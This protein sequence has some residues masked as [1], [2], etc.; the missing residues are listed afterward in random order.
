MAGRSK[1]PRP[2]SLFLDANVLYSAGC[3]DLMIEASLE[4]LCR[5]LWSMQVLTEF[6]AALLRTRPDLKPAQIHRL[7]GLLASVCPDALQR[8]RPVDRIAL[9]PLDDPADAHVLLGAY[10]ARAEIIITFN[11]RHFPRRILGPIGLVA[12]SPDQWLCSMAKPAPGV[13]NEIAERCRSRLVRPPL[14]RADHFE[15]LRRS[16]LPRFAAFLASR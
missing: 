10:E 7:L 1:S 9:P 3:R 2:V 8:H 4:G 13:M 15:A 11:L 16:G 12:M 14:S 5:C 6:K